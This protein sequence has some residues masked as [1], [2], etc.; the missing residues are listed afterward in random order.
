[1]IDTSDSKTYEIGKNLAI[2]ESVYNEGGE[3]IKNILERLL[4]NED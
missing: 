4:K 1:M 3:N 2:V